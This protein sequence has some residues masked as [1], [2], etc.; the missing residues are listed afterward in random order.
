MNITIQVV[1]QS[2]HAWEEVVDSDDLQEKVAEI[3]ETHGDI[4]RISTLDADGNLDKEIYRF[5]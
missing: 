1:A 2:G 5:E 3:V 4:E